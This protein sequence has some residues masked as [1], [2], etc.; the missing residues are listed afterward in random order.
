MP[1]I[2]LT[3]LANSSQKRKSTLLCW[4]VDAAAPG[5]MDPSR[6]GL[7]EVEAAAEDELLA[8]T[9]LLEA[10]AGVGNAEVEH[11]RHSVIVI[12][13]AVTTDESHMARKKK[14][15]MLMSGMTYSRDRAKS[16]APGLEVGP[17]YEVSNAISCC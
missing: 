12:N 10:K 3:A 13:S 8:D 16:Q 11:L 17:P 15:R 7:E 6:G 14:E 1:D 4:A 9:V 2:L 5:P